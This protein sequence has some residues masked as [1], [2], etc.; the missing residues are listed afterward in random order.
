MLF[1]DKKDRR[2]H[3]TVFEWFSKIQRRKIIDT[4]MAKELS[5]TPE[6]MLTHELQK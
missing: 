1:E 2:G 3:R 6:T 5:A 4:G